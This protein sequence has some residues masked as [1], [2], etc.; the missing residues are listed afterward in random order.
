MKSQVH[1]YVCLAKRKEIC[2]N[3]TIIIA[4]L[5]N[6]L[7]IFIFFSH[8]YVFYGVMYYFVIKKRYKYYKNL[9]E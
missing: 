3:F 7:D 9:F 6:E 1:I 2:Q 8:F 4:E 5:W